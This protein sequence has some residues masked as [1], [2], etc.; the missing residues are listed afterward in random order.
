MKLLVLTG[1]LLMLPGC[2][3][4]VLVNPPHPLLESREHRLCS[5][6]S[7]NANCL[8]GLAVEKA[9]IDRIEAYLGGRGQLPDTDE[10]IESRIRWYQLLDSG[11]CRPLEDIMADSG[12]EPSWEIGNYLMN[13]QMLGRKPRVVRKML[14]ND[15]EAMHI[16]S[17]EQEETILVRREACTRIAP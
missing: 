6:Q 4:A 3:Q 1:L 8:A 11:N 17:D 16:T 14:E 15:Q 2:G 12:M 5:G 13:L 9:A 7:D 10:T